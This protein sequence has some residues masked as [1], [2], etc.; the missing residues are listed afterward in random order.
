MGYVIAIL[1]ES[2][3]APMIALICLKE[4]SEKLI[5]LAYYYSSANWKRER[6]K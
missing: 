6:V 5:D 3:M 2:T 1:N 4:V